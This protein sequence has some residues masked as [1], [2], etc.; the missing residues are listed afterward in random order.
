MKR[1][2]IVVLLLVLAESVAADEKREKRMLIGELMKVMD[3]PGF[4]RSV[5]ETTVGND[6]M[7]RRAVV[8]LDYAAICDDRDVAILDRA[9]TAAELREVIAF[10]K[11]KTGQKALHAIAEVTIASEPA[12]IAKASEAYEAI[13]QE[14]VRNLYA[15]KPWLHTLD[16]MRSIATAAEAYATDNNRYPAAANMEELRKF[17]EPTYIRTLPAKDFWGNDY[18]WHISPDAQHYRLI[19]A[20][21]DGQMS[22]DSEILDVNAHLKLSDSLDDDIIY[23]DG[24]F[25]CIPTDAGEVPPPPP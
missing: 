25:I 8:R 19:S 23:Q 16:D 22:F 17:L 10:L 3:A 4:H 1:F 21:A 13:V 14:E 18:V 7:M 24:T 5:Y 11:T 15:K 6:E 2:A 9:L 12:I 20:G